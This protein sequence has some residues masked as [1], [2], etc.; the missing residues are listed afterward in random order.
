MTVF[1]YAVLIVIG[2]SILLSVMRGFLRE[3]MALLSWVVAF[4]VANLYTA[5]FAPMLPASIPTPELRLLAAFVALFLA[6]LLVMTLI[7]ITVGHFLKAIGIGPWDRAL[8]AVFGFARGMVMV[9]VLVLLAGLTSLPK[10][11]MWKNAMFSSPLETLVMQFKP[12]LPAELAK[13]LN[14]S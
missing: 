10:A 5:P 8:G 4:W 14:Y 2:V 11:P 9:L 1:D 6:T 13:R 3:V 12:W 7:S